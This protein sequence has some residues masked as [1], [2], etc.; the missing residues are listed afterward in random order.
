VDIPD[1]ERYE[2]DLEI[3]GATVSGVV[4]DRGC[5]P[6]DPVG[7]CELASPEGVATVI[8]RR[9]TQSARASVAV[10]P[11]ETAALTLVLGGDTTPQ[12]Y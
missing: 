3:A 11:G 5:G 12:R 1:A 8:A 9:N 2:L 6:T 4:V 7:V 10:R